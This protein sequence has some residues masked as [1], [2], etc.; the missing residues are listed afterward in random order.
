[1]YFFI[2]TRVK[3]KGKNNFLK[4]YAKLNSTVYEKI[5]LLN[6]LFFRNNLT[7]IIIVVRDRIF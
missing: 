7:K 4:F 6:L 5:I 1:M 2:H 3:I